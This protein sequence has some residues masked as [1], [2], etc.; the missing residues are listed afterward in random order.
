[1]LDNN[2][3]ARARQVLVGAGHECWTIDNAGLGDAA[4]DDVAVYAWD[5]H[6]I[7]VINDRAFAERLKSREMLG[8]HVLY[9]R[10]KDTRLVEYLSAHVAEVVQLLAQ[11]PPAH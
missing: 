5:K 2:V 1:M 3:D 4:D 7:P 10:C 8:G 11:A 6:A 9:G